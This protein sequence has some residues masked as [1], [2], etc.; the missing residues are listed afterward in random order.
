V[1]PQY[2]WGFPHGDADIGPI[3]IAEVHRGGYRHHH[4]DA[5]L[6]DTQRRE[7]GEGRGLDTHHTAYDRIAGLLLRGCAHGFAAK[8]H[9]SRRSLTHAQG[10]CGEQ[11]DDDV[12]VSRIS[13]LQQSRTG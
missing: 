5:L 6:F 11:R 2:A 10:I 9:P 4:I 13:N 3:A 7:A 8:R 1:D 12:E